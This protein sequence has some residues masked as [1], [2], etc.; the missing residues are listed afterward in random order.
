MCLETHKY[1]S[2]LFS[3][4]MSTNNAYALCCDWRHDKQCGITEGREGESAATRGPSGSIL[5]AVRADGMNWDG[6]TGFVFQGMNWDGWTSFVFQEI[7]HFGTY[8]RYTYVFFVF[9]SKS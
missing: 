9:L 8:K 4:I 2:W 6:W 5:G 1:R 7:F 3:L